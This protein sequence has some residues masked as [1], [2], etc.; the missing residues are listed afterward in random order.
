M[1]EEDQCSAEKPPEPARLAPWIAILL[2]GVAFILYFSFI[3]KGSYHPDTLIYLLQ[4]EKTLSTGHLQPYLTGYNIPMILGVLAVSVGKLLGLN[5][6][7]LLLNFL[8]VFFGAMGVVA[9]FLFLR[10]IFDG[11]TAMI[12]AGLLLILPMY[13][14]LSTFGGSQIIAMFFLLLGCYFLMRFAHGRD[15]VWGAVIALGLLGASRPQELVFLFLP[16]TYVLWHVLKGKSA[17]LRGTVRYRRTFECALFWL[18]VGGIILI[19]PLPFLFHDGKFPGIQDIKGLYIAYI[20]PNPTHVPVLY[21]M[22]AF[23]LQTVFH[24]LTSPALICALGGVF[25]LF[26]KDRRILAFLL[27][28]LLCAFVFYTSLFHKIMPT[29]RYLLLCM[30]PLLALM[31][32]FLRHLLVSGGCILK[33]MVMVIIGGLGIVYFQRVI[34]PLTIRHAVAVNNDFALWVATRT[35]PE[36]VIFASDETTFIKEFGRRDAIIL[37]YGDVAAWVG[38]AE[39]ALGRGKAVYLVLASGGAFE[40]AVLDHLSRQHEVRLM[41]EHFF[42]WWVHSL[43]ES[44]LSIQQL[45]RI[46]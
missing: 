46:R 14:S 38:R 37:P 27:L 25:F 21:R 16:V 15:T 42:E 41:G 30:P 11:P 24:E 7:V 4:V 8:N 13:F 17:F 12:S 32:Y 36:A 3:G 9:F 20:T 6:P 34:P 23:S 1:S 19:V 40:S 35:E 5:D 33:W 2:F 29:E 22:F 43:T 26:K 28:W 10:E 31:G 18:F 45:Y 39:E 44:Q